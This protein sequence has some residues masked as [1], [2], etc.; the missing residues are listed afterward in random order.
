M[1]DSYEALKETVFYYLKQDQTKAEMAIG[2]VA[3]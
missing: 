2:Q 1:K 3:T